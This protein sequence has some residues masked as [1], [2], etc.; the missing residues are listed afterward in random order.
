MGLRPLDSLSAGGAAAVVAGNTRLAR[1]EEQR[2]ADALEARQRLERKT[3]E[4]AAVPSSSANPQPKSVPERAAERRAAMKR[5]AETALRP[6][7]VTRVSGGGHVRRAKRQRAA[8]RILDAVRRANGERI[9]LRGVEAAEGHELRL[10]RESHSEASYQHKLVQ[11]LSRDEGK[12]LL[13]AP[14]GVV[15]DDLGGGADGN[16]DFISDDDE[17]EVTLPAH[18][19][20]PSAGTP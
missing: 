4:R 18:S 3:L 6:L 17:G 11:W 1:E 19:L 13:V 5:R 9:G 15:E 8:E 10:F 20:E 12:W 16:D 2:R 7:S 14:R